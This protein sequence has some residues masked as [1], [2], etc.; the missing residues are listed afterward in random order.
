MNNE[1]FRD[2]NEHND[3]GY[4]VIEEKTEEELLL[5][6]EASNA[7]LEEYN[8]KNKV[9]VDVFDRLSK[10]E[11]KVGKAVKNVNNLVNNQKQMKIDFETEKT[12][13]KENA[14]RINSLTDVTVKHHSTL[15]SLEESQKHQEDV[16]KGN[17][18]RFEKLERHS[19]SPKKA[20]KLAQIKRNRGRYLFENGY[21]EG[22][23]CTTLSLV[24]GF[25][26]RQFREDFKS[27][28][29]FY[30][31]AIPENKFDEVQNYFNTFEPVLE[32]ESTK[33]SRI[34]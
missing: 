17:S 23:E 8:A 33:I 24:H 20:R 31:H 26:T 14:K 4:E 3:L 9:L 2:E 21:F 27:E 11:I 7:L 16:N 5:R 10:V 15:S 22:T 1:N 12:N 28:D 29:I 30:Y 25:L 19:A 32:K 34:Y 6:Q 18:V 13:N